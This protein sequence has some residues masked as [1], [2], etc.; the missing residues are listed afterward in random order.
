[1]HKTVD[2][3]YYLNPQRPWC[4]LTEWLTHYNEERLHLGLD[5]LTPY[6]KT[7]KSV[8]P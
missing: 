1:V 2:D 7:L 6:E 5:G 8:T 4:S 3:E